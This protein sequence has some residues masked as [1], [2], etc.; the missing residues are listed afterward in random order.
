MVRSLRPP[1]AGMGEVAHHLHHRAHRL[2]H[3]GLAR[4]ARPPLRAWWAKTHLSWSRDLHNGLGTP[5]PAQR[6]GKCRTGLLEGEESPD[7][8]IEAAIRHPIEQL[9]EWVARPALLKDVG[10]L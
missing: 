8:R 4:G 10:E 9:L 6:E 1:P 7:R 2:G 5:C 3:D